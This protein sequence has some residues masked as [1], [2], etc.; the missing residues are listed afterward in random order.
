MA[1]AGCGSA[2]AVRTEPV[3]P[4]PTVASTGPSAESTVEP[5]PTSTPTPT[6]ES[7]AVLA[8][9]REFFDRQTEISAAPADQRRAMLQP[10]TTEPE[11][12]RVLG[13][14]LATQ[15][16]GQVGYGTSVLHPRVSRIDG[17][18]ATVTDCQDNSKVGRK[19]IDG[20]KLT[21]RG[22]ARD[23]TEATLRRGA[24]GAWRVAA[25]TYPNAPC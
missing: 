25:V 3:P 10:F 1:L 22:L 7:A 24:D 6:D 11:L 23:N 15:Q 2:P 19:K 9:Y 12:S 20:G 17:D 13:G 16:L 8:A 5:Q 18:Q 4:L 14:M 21:T